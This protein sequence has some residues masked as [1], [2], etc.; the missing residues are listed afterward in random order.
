MKTLIVFDSIFSNTR[1][2][3]QAMAAAARID[4][5]L[6]NMANADLLVVGSPIIAWKP[7]EGM[8]TFLSKIPDGHL[9]GVRVFHGDAAGKIAKRLE[10]AG[11]K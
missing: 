10:S 1:A 9:K 11:A 7:S 6:S 8:E 3:A 5:K 4:A 2:I